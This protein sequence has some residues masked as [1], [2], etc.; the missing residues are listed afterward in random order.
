MFRIPT[1][2]VFIISYGQE[3]ING[4][5]GCPLVL[6]VADRIECEVAVIAFGVY[7]INDV[8]N[9]FGLIDVFIKLVFLILLVAQKHIHW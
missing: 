6:F 9:V 5:S 8:D 2:T 3:N 4:F 1:Y 7:A